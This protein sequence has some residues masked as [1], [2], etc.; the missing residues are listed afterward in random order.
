[1]YEIMAVYT[2][3]WMFYITF[4]LLT[5]FVLLN[6]LAGIIFDEFIGSSEDELSNRLDKIE[7]MIKYIKNQVSK[8]Q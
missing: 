7:D 4:I 6:M 1:M 3:S 2:L 8:D 5:F